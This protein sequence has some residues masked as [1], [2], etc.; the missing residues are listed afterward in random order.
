VVPTSCDSCS[1]AVEPC[2][3]ASEAEGMA[4]SAVL[5][6]PGAP[7]HLGAPCRSMAGGI[8]RYASLR[9]TERLRSLLTTVRGASAERSP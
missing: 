3:S 6:G 5:S 8:K 4:F 2:D 9:S 1:D 7:L